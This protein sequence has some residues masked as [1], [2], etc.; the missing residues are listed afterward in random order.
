LAR[1]FRAFFCTSSKNSR[2]A[3]MPATINQRVQF[4]CIRF[5][6]LVLELS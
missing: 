6:A 4:E 3:I 5:V 1:N 2:I